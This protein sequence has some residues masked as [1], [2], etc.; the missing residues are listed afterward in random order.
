M[1]GTIFKEC[2]LSFKT[3]RMTVALIRE[4]LQLLK[5]RTKSSSRNRKL[6]TDRERNTDSI[7]ELEEIIRKDF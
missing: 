4:K 3:I 5:Y 7:K 6:F 1:T 2:L